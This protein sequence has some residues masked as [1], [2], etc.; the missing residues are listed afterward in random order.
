MPNIPPILPPIPPVAPAPIAVGQQHNPPLPQLPTGTILL[1]TVAGQDQ[2]GNVQI[3]TDTLQMVLNTHYPLSKGVQIAVRLEQPLTPQPDK[4]ALPHI[5]I[6][7]VDGKTPQPI[8]LPQSTALPHSV[9]PELAKP[10]GVLLDITHRSGATIPKVAGEA[11][12][13]TQTQPQP[14]AH[15]PARGIAAEV[16]LSEGSKATAVLLRPAM[17][18]QATTLLTQLVQS[19]APSS[20]ALQPTP[21]SALRPGLQF[22]VQIVQT[23]A[24][25]LPTANPVPPLSNHST[26]S[27]S[28][29]SSGIPQSAPSFVAPPSTP[30]PSAQLRSGYASYARQAPAMLPGSP[31]PAASSIP[32]NQMPPSAP[33]AQAASIPVAASPQQPAQVQNPPAVAA[34]QAQ[35]LASGGTG[36]ISAPASPATPVNVPQNLSPK[37]VEQLLTRAEAQPL[38]QGQLAAVVMGKEPAGALIVQTRLGMF[39]L[40]QMQTDGAQQPG[41]VLT[42]QVRSIQPPQ[43]T[44]QALPIAGSAGLL[45]T[46]IQMTAEWSALNELATVLQSMQGSMA[47]QSLQRIV[48]HVGNNLGAGLLFFMNVLRKGDVSE[49]LGRDVVDK[50]EKI[51]KGDLVQRLGNDLSAV[52]SL[53][54]DQPPGNWQAMFFPVMVEKELHHA[55]MFMKQEADEKK[56]GGSGTR[57]IVELELSNLGPMQIDGFIKKHESATQFDLVMRTMAELPD[58]IRTDIYHIFD[59]A[60]KIANFKGSLHFRQVSEFTVLPL[61]EM[62]E[63]EQG[64]DSGSIMA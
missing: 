32:S 5:R 3:K 19:V 56:K 8:P 27:P 60:Q 49:W 63:A 46:A 25:P 24:S 54:V 1:G 23:I 43:A 18:Q 10:I 53:F 39:T 58:A 38:P 4:N 17:S 28:P 29:Q 31:A 50:L 30:L 45:A 6:V 61:E 35:T 7:S 2:N 16:T 52:R 14:A 22:Q 51:G 9:N 48:P 57:F 15:A 12:A 21:V 36:G 55:Q 64:K 47:A 13:A 26:T 34:P 20:Q 37:M 42:W 41:S 33:L 59:S 44:A 11:S 40:P 62:H